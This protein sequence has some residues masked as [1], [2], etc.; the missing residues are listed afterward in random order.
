MGP[1]RQASARTR[2]ERDPAIAAHA[3][4]AQRQRCRDGARTLR[5]ADGERLQPANQALAG[6]HRSDVATPKRGAEV[7]RFPHRSTPGAGLGNRLRRQQY[8]A[9]FTQSSGD[10]YLRRHSASHRELYRRFCPAGWTSFEHRRTSRPAHARK[11]PDPR[12][13]SRAEMLRRHSAVH[14]RQATL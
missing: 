3:D 8:F 6:D 2:L 5:S 11:R 10:R 4:A 9:R 7:S 14:R 13:D 1:T 12:G